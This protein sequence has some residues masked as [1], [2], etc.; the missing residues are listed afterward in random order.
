M[1]TTL[2]FLLACSSGFALV[3]GKPATPGQFPSL[4][5][6]EDCT[7]TK[8]GEHHFLLAAHCVVEASGEDENYTNQIK[9]T[10]S[11]GVTLSLDRALN[12]V[13]DKWSHSV[14]VARVFV[15]PAYRYS[16][17]TQ[18]W[19]K[20]Q[21]I[22]DVAVVVVAEKTPDIPILPVS[23]EPLIAGA[24]VTKVGYG[25]PET[26]EDEIRAWVS[27]GNRQ[28]LHADSTIVESAPAIAKYY[29]TA[30]KSKRDLAFYSTNKV[31]EFIGGNFSVTR[32]KFHRKPPSGEKDKGDAKEVSLGF[33]DSGGPLLAKQK[34]KWA[35]VGVN[36]K[37]LL[38]L[39]A[40][41]GTKQVPVAYDLHTRLDRDNFSGTSAWLHAVTTLTP[42]RVK[43]HASLDGLFAT[44]VDPAAWK[45]QKEPWLTK[46]YLRE[47]GKSFKASLTAATGKPCSLGLKKLE[48][49]DLNNEENR[50]FALDPN[51]DEEELPL[52]ASGEGQWKVSSK[53]ELKVESVLVEFVGPKPKI[54]DSACLFRLE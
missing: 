5:L 19:L 49:Y 42:G 39:A 15:H 3:G 6:I 10:F 36:A 35:V 9:S 11:E 34:G 47:E 26:T 44:V 18:P 28:L 8:I 41:H 32:G 1:K 30:T 17:V 31:Q 53:Q 2:W 46:E 37:S 27:S 12:H 45:K 50:V 43:S 51:E 38:W 52:K 13:K 25:C 16:S 40:E 7:A 14:T 29:S 24:T 22:S 48:L 20:P 54:D 4:V 21:A 23:D 33:S